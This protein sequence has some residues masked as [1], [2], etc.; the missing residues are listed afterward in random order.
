MQISLTVAN[1]EQLVFTLFI[2]FLF[3]YGFQS[4]LR[5]GC[6]PREL[7]KPPGV[8]H[9]DPVPKPEAGGI[10]E[11]AAAIANRINR[12]DAAARSDWNRGATG[13][14]RISY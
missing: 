9:D 1:F 8:V 14:L 4:C 2:Y 10:D 5:E 13:L 6:D 11:D 12:N 3:V 7:L